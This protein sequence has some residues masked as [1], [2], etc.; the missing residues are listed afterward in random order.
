M[1]IG[2]EPIKVRLRVDVMDWKM[3]ETVKTEGKTAQP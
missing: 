1:V 3:E 2:S